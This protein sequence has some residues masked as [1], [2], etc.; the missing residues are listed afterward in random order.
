[1]KS[2][3][4]ALKLPL[5]A[6]GVTYFI[7]NF[8]NTLTKYQTKQSIKS[9]SKELAK[10]FSAT[11]KD[12][13]YGMYVG[14]PNNP[15]I[16]EN[17]NI[18]LSSIVTTDYS[19]VH[20]FDTKKVYKR[21][22]YSKEHVLIAHKGD[23]KV[24][25]MLNRYDRITSLKAMWM[26]AGPQFSQVAYGVTKYRREAFIIDSDVHYSSLQQAKSLMIDFC[27]AYSLPFLSYLL[28]NPTSGHIQAGWFTNDPYIGEEA[29]KYHSETI[30]NLAQLY[31][32]FCVARGITD[33]KAGDT[34]F[35][36]P[37]CKNPFWAG[38]DAE[39]YENSVDKDSFST[40]CSD[41]VNG[42]SSYYASRK[43]IKAKKDAVLQYNNISFSSIANNIEIEQTNNDLESSLLPAR[44]LTIVNGSRQK[45][46]FVNGSR[47]AYRCKAFRE[48]L[49]KNGMPDENTA[50]EYYINTIMPAA[51]EATGKPIE[52]W[53]EVKSAFYGTYKWAMAKYNPCNQHA[54]NAS[55]L[56]AL[57][58]FTR[59]VNSFVE[60]IDGLYQILNNKK[61]TRR[62][63]AIKL[64]MPV[65]Q[66]QSMY[67]KKGEVNI[68]Y[69]TERLNATESYLNSVRGN[70]NKTRVVAA[71]L[72][73]YHECL[74][75]IQQKKDIIN[76]DN[77][78][79]LQYNNISFSSIANNIEIE[80]TNNDLN[81]TN[82]ST[83]KT[84]YY[85]T[86][87]QKTLPITSAIPIDYLE[88][89]HNGDSYKR[90]KANL[91]ANYIDDSVANL[92]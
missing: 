4:L 56:T 78:A 9:A 17:R 33:P 21:D 92:F 30:R 25:K 65:S 42:L 6:R 7:M 32:D 59:T 62:A 52:S 11:T 28:R 24:R 39:V 36:G 27:N 16:K 67:Y 12:A 31:A 18:I 80:Q 83:I 84:T 61:I 64:N 71:A 88:Q 49:W 23:K 87:E 45:N 50:K 81:T 86:V 1:M 34:C 55:K 26:I 15:S 29:F 13:C 5:D 68:D 76:N 82:K 10:R 41:H 79:V 2:C 85:D 69:F 35:N 75:L 44:K 90:L 46:K 89:L 77:N 48:W 20:Y 72:A 47:D 60:H 43:A 66:V 40:I 37:S 57:G 58:T 54:K 19:D 14:V 8:T 51:A 73:C 3:P 38:F 74:E 53:K 22:A 63:L 91:D 70:D